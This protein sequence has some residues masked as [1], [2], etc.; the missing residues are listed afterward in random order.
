M[1][2][3]VELGQVRQG[4]AGDRVADHDRG[5]RLIDVSRS[6]FG[7]AFHH[8]ERIERRLDHELDRAERARVENAEL[9]HVGEF[10]IDDMPQPLLGSVVENEQAVFEGFGHT[11]R[12][13]AD[14]NDVGLLEAVVIR[15]QEK[16]RSRRHVVLE[17]LSDRM[18]GALEMLGH[19][20]HQHLV[21]LV[22]I[23]VE[24]LRSWPSST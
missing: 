3:A 2:E 20:R 4:L 18:P 17:I 24:V 7:H 21:L 12:S 19:P 16:R 10:V 5:R 23:N 11:A 13:F 6:V 8:P 1:A 9:H 14:R 15:V 22:V